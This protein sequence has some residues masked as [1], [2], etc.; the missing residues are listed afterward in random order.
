MTTASSFRFL[1]AYDSRSRKLAVKNQMGVSLHSQ[2]STGGIYWAECS[3]T[4][5]G[6]SCLAL[7]NP[8]FSEVS[9]TQFFSV[10]CI[11]CFAGSCANRLAELAL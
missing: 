2:L 4:Q 7:V 6:R 9:P 5:A 11:R 3:V 8:S 10:I 1:F